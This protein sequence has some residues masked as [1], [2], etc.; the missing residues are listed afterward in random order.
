[1]PLLGPP[2]SWSRRR[3]LASGLAACASQCLLPATRAADD[4]D[5]PHVRILFFG[6]SL[7]ATN[8][9]PAVV[10]ELMLSSKVLAPHIGSCLQAGYGLSRHA[11]D[12]AAMDLL[13]KGADGSP[14]DVIVVQEHSI[15]AA[16]A[17]Q[18]EEARELMVTGLSKI[19]AAARAQNPKALVV[20]VQLWARHESLWQSQ[21]AEALRTGTNALD[22]H[23]NTRRAC[24]LVVQ[25]ALQRNPGAQV[26]VS[27]VGDF[28]NLVLETYPAMPLYANDGQHPELL[29][30]VLTGLVLCGTIGGRQM[31]DQASWFG[32]LPFSQ[33]AKLKKVLLDHPEVFANAGK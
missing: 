3:L 23:R 19:L 24:S 1:M 18:H 27:P 28:W 10:G 16:A 25:E 15:V 8:G 21:D 33:F 13:K 30:T 22:A 31:V 20:L 26:L 9:L 14:W 11:S 12:T 17:A 29:G 5:V 4:G 7:I 6:N 2:S 32:E